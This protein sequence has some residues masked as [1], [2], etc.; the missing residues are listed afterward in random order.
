[1][2]NDPKARWAPSTPRPG[3]RH[4]TSR[5]SCPRALDAWIPRL[6]TPEAYPARNAG[7]RGFGWLKGWRRVATR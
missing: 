1:M 2:R 5:P 7:A 6:A 3:W 4:G